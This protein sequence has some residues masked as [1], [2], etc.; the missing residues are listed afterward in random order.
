MIQTSRGPFTATKLILATGGKALPASGSDGTGYTLAQGLGH[1]ITQTWPAL[2]PLVLQDNH[3]LMDL[4]GIALDVQLTLAG[5]SGKTLHKQSGAL[6]LTHFGLSGPAAMDISRHLRDDG[7][8]APRKLTCNF[9]PDLSFEKLEA[10]WLDA[11]KQHPTRAV[12]TQLRKRFP[13]RFSLVI[14]EKFLGIELEMPLSRLSRDDRRALCH[15]LTALPLPVVGDR[16]YKFAEVTAGGIPMSEVTTAT[17]ASKQC[18]GLYPLRRSARCRWPHRRIQLPMG[19]VYRPPRRPRG[20][21]AL[22]PLR[23]LP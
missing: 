10:M 23:C 2:V 3:F 14:L 17:M 21:A 1:T 18:D 7:D 12:H 5:S 15:A 19:L 20:G 6:L 9:C 13:E 8:Q 22:S 4:S 11:A 16:G